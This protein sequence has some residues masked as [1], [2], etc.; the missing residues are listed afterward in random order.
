MLIFVYWFICLCDYFWVETRT[1]RDIHVY[2]RQQVRT[3]DDTRTH[4]QASYKTWTRVHSYCRLATSHPVGRHIL[5]ERWCGTSVCMSTSPSVSNYLHDHTSIQLILSF[6][7]NFESRRFSWEAWECK[8][9]RVCARVCMCRMVSCTGWV[10]CAEQN[11]L[12]WSQKEEQSRNREEPNLGRSSG[13]TEQNDDKHAAGHRGQWHI[14]KQA[15]DQWTKWKWWFTVR[16]S[17]FWWL[18]Y[19]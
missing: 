1:S 3:G 6:R 17:K 19:F 4:T 10:D 18:L 7:A 12:S 16:M 14:P 9:A 5:Y 15:E 11:T 8:V 2:F 13:Q